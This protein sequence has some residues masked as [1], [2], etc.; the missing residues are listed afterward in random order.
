MKEDFSELI[1]YLDE[2]FNK[3]EAQLETKA[4]KEDVVNLTNAVDALAG[5]VENAFQEFTMLTAKINRMENWI[6]EA[7]EKLDIEFEA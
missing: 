5:K 3:I 2:R 4:D 6:K 1:S 7:S